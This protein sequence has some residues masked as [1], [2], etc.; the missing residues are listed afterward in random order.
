MTI[1]Y[2]IIY[3]FLNFHQI[4]NCDVQFFF[5]IIIAYLLL[6]PLLLHKVIELVYKKKLHKPTF[7]IIAFF[8]LIYIGNKNMNSSFKSKINRYGGIVKLATVK[9]KYSYY[10]TP[11]NVFVESIIEGEIKNSKFPVSKNIYN[12]LH[13]R[14]S[15]M[16]V[17]SIICNDWIM[18]YD[19]TPS[20][21]LIQQC[22]D[23]CFYK[24]GKIVDKL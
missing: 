17:Y 19:L 10:N 8:I 6:L 4:F 16:L 7:F 20:P 11:N 3:L 22:K 23:G 2:G 13:V 5:I 24:E 9:D 12:K 15:I 18:P 1:I 14:D 21:E